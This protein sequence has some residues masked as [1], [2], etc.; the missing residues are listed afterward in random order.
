MHLE[1]QPPVL[2][3]GPPIWIRLPKPGKRC[4]HCELSRTSLCELVIPSAA[5]DWKPPVASTVLR[6]RG[7]TRGIRL[8]SYES[9]MDYLDSLLKGGRSEA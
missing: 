3:S 1:P 9:L 4:P 8:I 7:A 6:R 2:V 5:N